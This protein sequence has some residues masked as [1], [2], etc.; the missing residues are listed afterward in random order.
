MEKRIKS[1]VSSFIKDFDQAKLDFLDEALLSLLIE[2]ERYLLKN[3]KDRYVEKIEFLLDRYH[4]YRKL[5][6]DSLSGKKCYKKNF[7]IDKIYHSPARLIV[8]LTHNCQ[9][10]CKYCRVSK[11]SATMSEKILKKAVELMFTS[12]SP[13]MQLQFFGGEPLLRVDLLKKAVLYAEKLNRKAGK[14]LFFIL[15][16]NG[17][18]MTRENIGFIKDHRFIVEY[19]I[20]GEAQ[21]QML[22]RRAKDGKNY[23][24]RMMDNFVGL[25][26]TSLPYYSISV[27]MPENVLSM[28]D[29]FVHLAAN[30]FEHLQMNY[31]LG[32][33]WPDSVMRQF[34]EQCR[35]IIS[36]S[37]K[38][39][40]DFINLS[41]VRKEPVV[42]NA[43]LTVDFDGGVY[44]ESGICL[45][46][47]FLSMKSKFLVGNVLEMDNLNVYYSSWFQNLFRLS[48]VYAETNPVFRKIIVNNVLMGRRFESFLK[49]ER[50]KNFPG[51][52]SLTCEQYVSREQGSKI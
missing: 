18:E 40:V 5:I 37:K 16:T 8:L 2:K 3:K 21:S 31:S 24:N 30:G 12:N 28:F 38:N 19:S 25:R 35:K 10:R 41:S 4:D 50:E 11:F 39:K 1:I 36:Y 20:D 46:E 49:K 34:F 26:S 9:L 15:T 17:I 44:L 45:E 23:Y 42:L 27:V 43:E 33:Y 29:S 32:I 48:K 6:F 7:L 14:N 51:Q 13:D 22:S 52:K 47:D